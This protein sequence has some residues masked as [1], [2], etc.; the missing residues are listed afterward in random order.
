MWLRRRLSR[1]SWWTSC[2]A[3]HKPGGFAARPC[4]LG[5]N[6]TVTRQDMIV[7]LDLLKET[8]LEQILSGFPVKTDLFKANVSIRGGFKNGYDEY[9]RTRHNVC[10]NMNST[11]DFRKELAF[12]ASVAQ[13]LPPAAVP[14]V[15]QI[16]DYGKDGFTTELT[17]GAMIAVKGARFFDEALE[18]AVYLTP[19]DG[20]D[21]LPMGKVNQVKDRTIICHLPEDLAAG[22]YWITVALGEGRDC[23]LGSFKQLLTIT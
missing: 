1:K 13:V 21:P 12:R 2:W 16:F 18:T 14:I 6:T 4:S 20:G 11:M 8:V 19:E 23:R 3:G 17:S 5:K 9:D 7:V 10:V 15:R 22:R